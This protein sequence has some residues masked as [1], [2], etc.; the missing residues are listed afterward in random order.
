MVSHILLADFNHYRLKDL[1]VVVLTGAGISA[2]SGIKTFRD[3]NGLWEDH[4]IEDV[5]T[6]EGFEKDPSLV[7][8]FYNQRRQQ[9]LSPAVKPN[10]AHVALAKLE[11][12]LGANFTLVTQNVDNL[13]Q[14][15]G[16]HNVLH[17]HGSLLSA[18]CLK[19]HKSIRHFADLTQID[20]CQ[21]CQIPSQLRPDIVWF[22]EMPKY[23]N[24]IDDVIQ[25]AD[26][27]VSIGTSGN[28]YPAAGFV[29]QANHYGAYSLELN[30]E[31]S[32]GHSAFREKHC[33]LASELVSQLVDRLL[34]GNKF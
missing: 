20:K 1:E 15:A 2:E 33:G 19:S 10:K 9:L 5:A 25:K 32:L 17:M 18:R 21:C 29:N 24:E 16:S 34:L 7:Y 12:V 22:G 4:R 31:P 8:Q 26:L 6:P 30:L 13:H 28:V 23:M 14:Q 11:A 27:F 3:N